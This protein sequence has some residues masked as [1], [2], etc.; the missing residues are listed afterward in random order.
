M[1]K[2]NNI[3]IIKDRIWQICS[4]VKEAI[5]NVQ[6]HEIAIAFAF[7][8]R[9][10]CLVGK[11]SQECNS[12]YINNKERLSEERL[13]EKLREISGGYSFY[14]HSGYTFKGII[15][16][17]GS[18][19]VVLNTYL[20]GFSYNVLHF[21]R[22]MNFSQ[23][24]ALLLRQSRYL[25]ELIEKFEELD[26]SASSFDNEEFAELIYLIISEGMIYYGEHF[27][28]YELSNLIQKCLLNKDV[29]ED[30]NEVITLYDPV[31]GTGHMLVSAGETAKKYAIHQEN[32][33]MYGQEIAVFP[34]AVAEALVLLSGSEFSTVAYGD[35]LTEDAFAGN[36]FHYILAD[37]PFGLSWKPIQT[38][39]QMEAL[40]MS[41]RFSIGLPA[42]Y[43]SQFLFIEHIISKMSPE[44][45]RAAFITNVAAL[46]AGDARSGESRIR[47]WMFEQDLVETI[48]ALP[49][50]SHTV[51]SIP[52]YLW[53]LSN[54]KDK[55]QIG[56]VRL[57]DA[58]TMK[59]KSRRKG[60]DSDMVEFIV[61]E[62]QSNI[63]STRSIIVKKE[64]FGYYEFNLLEDG[65]KSERVTISLDKDISEFI[66]KERQPYAKG[67]ITIDYSSVEKGYSVDFDRFFEQKNV[68]VT[69]LI[70]A[71]NDLLRVI[72]AINSIK[73]DIACIKGRA[74][75][76]SKEEL[77]L[78]AATEVV[79]T[80]SRNLSKN[81]DGQRLPFVS[82]SYLRKPSSE[83]PLHGITPKTKCSTKDDVIVIIK[84]DNAGEVFRG[85][86]GILTSTV[87][88]IK[89]ID[90]NI[91]TPK[92]LYYLLKGYEKSLRS[93]AKGV[94]MKSLD[95]KS[96]LD[97]KCIIPSIKEQH[98]LVGYLDDIVGKIDSIIEALGNADNVF[99]AYRQTLI[100]NVVR[101]RVIIS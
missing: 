20:Q 99:S 98:R 42:V 50:G 33:S 19:D 92:Y 65:K 81:S 31:C 54:K 60:L 45:S 12:F 94:A 66:E 26:F 95:S 47:R 36:Q 83:E 44:G 53:I 82:V 100:E 77:P 29:R 73:Q 51:A 89:C 90:E 17:K 67:K 1:I 74:E 96:I 75:D 34:C 76:K 38:K 32:I 3:E 49:A 22:G 56:K 14:N 40:D 68:D 15:H 35:T 63:I 7:L 79:L 23:N 28:S 85:V 58:S 30:K 48:I 71:T 87:A 62:Y 25:V 93:M 2:D 37:N 86:D 27:T 46:L 9:I 6:Q 88:A 10:D 80:G 16:A 43:D 91:I 64:Q 72:D 21:L 13:G 59:I 69:S 24:Q 57:I 84:G 41:G 18:I 101:G 55:G 70:D 61:D 8:R 4:S 39:I 52:I 97:L 11:Y 78:R 5:P